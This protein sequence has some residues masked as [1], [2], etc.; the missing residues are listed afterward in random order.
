M[1]RRFFSPKLVLFYVGTIA[2]VVALFSGVTQYGET[3]LRAAPKIQGRYRIT[4]STQ[5]CLTGRAL[6]IEQS[7]VY[8]NAIL[9]PVEPLGATG[10]PTPDRPA[11][12]GL[13]FSG[14]LQNQRLY[15]TAPQPIDLVCAPLGA[16]ATAID[17]EVRLATLTG[18]IKTTPGN[19]NLSEDPPIGITAELEP[20]PPTAKP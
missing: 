2:A 4:Q 5:A 8:V 9:Q 14:L 20:P 7:G 12:A 13:R 10:G 1:K 18:Q 19:S 15:L 11:V 3:H 6:V 17:V 16:K